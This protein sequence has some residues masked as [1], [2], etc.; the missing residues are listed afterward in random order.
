MIA[1]A[2]LLIAVRA[3]AGCAELTAEE[4]EQLKYDSEERDREKQKEIRSHQSFL[5]RKEDDNQAQLSR[6]MKDLKRK[7]LRNRTPYPYGRSAGQ[8]RAKR[9]LMCSVDP[10]IPGT[11]GIFLPTEKRH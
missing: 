4:L 6:L 10:V 8:S 1:L 3:A 11:A 7:E 5:V 9:L 2:V